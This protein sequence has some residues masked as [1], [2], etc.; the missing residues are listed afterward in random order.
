MDTVIPVNKKNGI[1]TGFMFTEYSATA[2]QKALDQAI[3]AYQDK[4]LW[5]KIMVNGMGEDFS[6]SASA[7]AYLKLYER[8]V[9]GEIK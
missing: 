6:W 2:F 8:L 1:G 3:E 4:K 5:K 7:K 9:K